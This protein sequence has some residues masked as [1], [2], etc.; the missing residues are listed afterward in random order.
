MSNTERANE[1]APGEPE[2]AAIST[3]VQNTADA[4]ALARW[5]TDKLTD[6]HQTYLNRTYRIDITIQFEEVDP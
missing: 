2:Q 1:H 3:T 5:V 6:A 4:F